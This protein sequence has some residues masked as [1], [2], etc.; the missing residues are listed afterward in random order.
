MCIRCYSLFRPVITPRPH[1]TPLN[2]FRVR[3]KNII[4]S[5]PAALRCKPQSLEFFRQGLRGRQGGKAH[6][7]ELGVCLRKL[8]YTRRRGWVESDGGGFK[9]QWYPPE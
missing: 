3:L 5:L 9:S 8:N 1:D 2:Y 6:A 7:G 4:D